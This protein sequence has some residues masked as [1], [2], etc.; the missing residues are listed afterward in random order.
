MKFL[1]VL[2][3]LVP[4]AAGQAPPSLVPILNTD[5]AF[6][7]WALYAH[8]VDRALHGVPPLVWHDNLSNYAQ[9]WANQCVWAHSNG[10][11][12]E[13]LHG[14]WIRTPLDFINQTRS[15]I[16]DGWYKEIDLYDYNKPG[17]AAATG[18]FTQVVWK[19]TTYVGCA[20]NTTPCKSGV[21]NWFELV[22]EYWPA[23]NV[24]NDAIFR[25]NVPPP[26]VK[27][28]TN[29]VLGAVGSIVNGVGGAVGSL[30]GGG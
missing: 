16:H 21:W 2:A 4:L 22:C 11:Y 6:R 9:Q 20:W 19:N 5:P 26:L 29:P 18:H 1:S 12:G 7:A 15:G 17:F 14:L 24:L 30:I 27:Q 25:A 10:M 23:G 3:A 28:V 8:N 13:N